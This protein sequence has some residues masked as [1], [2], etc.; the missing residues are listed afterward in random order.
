VTRAQ[1]DSPS[2]IRRA[3][4][5]PAPQLLSLLDQLPSAAQL[6]TFMSATLPLPE[7]RR[8]RGHNQE[9]RS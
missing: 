9:D 5:V 1:G 2:K 3:I 4:G 6:V 7:I 8:S